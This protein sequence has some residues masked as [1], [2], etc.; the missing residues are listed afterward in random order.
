LRPVLTRSQEAHVDKKLTPAQWV[1]VIAGVLAFIGSF[2]AW[3][4]VDTAFGDASA[5]AWDEGFFPTYTW[6]G[7][8]G[9]VMAA[10]ILVTTF[11]NVNLPRDVLGFTWGQIHLILGFFA[12]LLVV[13]YLIGPGDEFGIGFWLSFLAGV[14]LLVGAV[15]LTREPA[16]T[17]GGD[18]P[19]S[20]RPGR[21]A[22][23][24]RTA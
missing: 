24:G 10:Q 14:A 9:L 22:R 13:S 2:L 20:P 19:R 6:V 5:N 21:P 11:A 1:I 12:A 23:C 15:M 18:V 7:I 4:S 16:V 3:F 17:A 8:F